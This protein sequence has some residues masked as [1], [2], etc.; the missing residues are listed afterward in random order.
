MSNEPF[1]KQNPMPG[2]SSLVCEARGLK[3]IAKYRSAHG[4]RTPRVLEVTSELM[5]LERI[6]GVAPN[7]SDWALLGKGLAKL[8]QVTSDSF[9]FEEDNFIGLSP[10]K[11]NLSKNWGEFF[12]AHRLLFQVNLIQSDFIKEKLLADLEFYKKSL[13]ELLN[14]H[15]PRPSLLHG[16]LW[17][18]NVLFDKG[19]PWLIDPAVYYGD[20]ECDLAMTRMFGG[21]SEDFYSSYF[22]SYPL[23]KN[24]EMR[25]RIYNL[26]HYLNHL[27]IFGHSY[28]P[29]VENE[30]FYLSKI[31]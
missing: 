24:S 7:P 18:G 13:I 17:S 2:S 22:E 29:C 20:R 6:S 28:M 3:E 10:Q 5:T 23:P 12:Y 14:A 16:D 21:F 15:D 4:L 8:H 25:I 11:N 19:G 27:N 30:F 9:G 31:F 26:Y 1:I